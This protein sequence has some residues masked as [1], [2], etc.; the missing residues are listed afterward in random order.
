MEVWAEGSVKMGVRRN[1]YLLVIPKLN[2]TKC[3]QFIAKL[4]VVKKL[5]GDFHL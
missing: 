4:V 1:S 2:V 5:S 3:F